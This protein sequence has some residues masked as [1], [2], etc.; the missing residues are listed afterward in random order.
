[1]TVLNCPYLGGCPL[2]LVEHL[3]ASHVL[4]EAV[5]ESP[6]PGGGPSFFLDVFSGYLLPNRTQNV[7]KFF[8]VRKGAVAPLD[9]VDSAMI[10]V[11]VKP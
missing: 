6:C 3:L 11:E 7:Q 8:R 10:S 2:D 9:L 5:Q 4:R 1:M